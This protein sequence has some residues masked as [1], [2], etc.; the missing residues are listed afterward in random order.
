M[1][2]ESLLKKMDLL[3]EEIIRLRLATE[4]FVVLLA[5]ISML[6]DPVKRLSRI[7]RAIKVFPQEITK[8]YLDYIIKKA[9]ESDMIFDQLAE[10]LVEGCGND[11]KNVISVETIREYYGFQS[12]ERWSKIVRSINPSIK[13]ALKIIKKGECHV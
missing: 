4:N 2:I 13:Y 12:A 10:A 6:N 1:S 9:K 11:A 3:E 5:E 7:V 8:I